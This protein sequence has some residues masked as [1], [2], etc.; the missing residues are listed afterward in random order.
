MWQLISA[1]SRSCLGLRECLC[2]GCT[3]GGVCFTMK[4]GQLRSAVQKQLWGLQGGFSLEQLPECSCLFTRLGPTV[5]LGWASSRLPLLRDLCILQCAVQPW[6][7]PAYPTLISG[8]RDPIRRR[9]PG[10]PVLTQKPNQF[11]VITEAKYHRM[12][13]VGRD[14]LV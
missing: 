2:C 3:A 4:P 7:L 5:V 8:V 12:G 9:K 11:C 1:T 13:S 10:D 6:P 14:H